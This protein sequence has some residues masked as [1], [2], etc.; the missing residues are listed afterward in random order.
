MGFVAAVYIVRT[1]EIRREPKGCQRG[2]LALARFI[3]V[4]FRSRVYLPN[5]A[6]ETPGCVLRRQWFPA[7]ITYVKFLPYM[8]QERRVIPG[9]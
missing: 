7:K 6:A 3:N 2:R 4:C 8:G 9:S 5:A 1:E